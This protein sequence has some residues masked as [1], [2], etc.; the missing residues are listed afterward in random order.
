[1]TLAVDG[2]GFSAMIFGADGDKAFAGSDAFLQPGI[3]MLHA[4]FVP[5]GQRLYR[6]GHGNFGSTNLVVTIE[7]FT[8]ACSSYRAFIACM[9]KHFRASSGY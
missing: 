8:M 6:F 3:R 7:L 4:L 2:A 1:M 9:L 5:P